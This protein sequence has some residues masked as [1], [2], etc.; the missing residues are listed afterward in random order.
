MRSCSDQLKEPDACSTTF[1]EVQ[2]DDRP[3]R[4]VMLHVASS[5]YMLLGRILSAFRLRVRVFRI[6]RKPTEFVLGIIM[7]N[8][9]EVNGVMMY[10]DRATA[11]MMVHMVGG[12]YE[13]GTTS[14]LSKKLQVGMT[15]VDVGANIG[16]FTLYAARKAGPSGRVF[17]FEPD[18]RCQQ[19]LKMGIRR[20][21]FQSRVTLSCKAV[22]RNESMEELFIHNQ[23]GQSTLIDTLGLPFVKVDVTSLDEYFGNMGWPSVD[24]VK[25]DVE[26]WEVEVLNGM[27]ELVRKNPNLTLIVEFAPQGAHKSNAVDRFFEQLDRLGFNVLFPLVGDQKIDTGFLTTTPMNRD[28]IIELVGSSYC[29]LLCRRT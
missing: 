13:R 17:A 10:H 6:L 29:N 26:G 15:F 4:S 21:A 23:V 27:N 7:P 22:G 25:V 20:N 2:I 19:L 5:V 18:P 3:A 9:V 16:Y 8:P 24:F 11:T 28:E 12:G 14:Y 1:T